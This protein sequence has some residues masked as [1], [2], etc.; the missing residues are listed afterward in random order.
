MKEDYFRWTKE[1]VESLAT[2]R[3]KGNSWKMISGRISALYDEPVTA[4]ACRSKFD[5]DLKWKYTKG[6]SATD[7][8]L[9]NVLRR[10]PPALQKEII[11]DEIQDFGFPRFRWLKPNATEEEA[12]EALVSHWCAY[13][14]YT[15]EIH[16][17]SPESVARDKDSEPAEW[18]KRWTLTFWIWRP[19]MDMTKDEYRRVTRDE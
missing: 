18:F 19:G 16:G 15:N 12:R 9:S 7:T 10:P 2:L 3:E 6:K 13:V 11:R 17:M 5:R 14:D 4:N 1:A 8:E